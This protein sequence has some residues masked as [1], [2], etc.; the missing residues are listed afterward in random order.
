MM[1]V[2]TQTNRVLGG[3]AIDQAARRRE[4]ER[5]CPESIRRRAQAADLQQAC[6]RTPRTATPPA[7]VAPDAA[8]LL[9]TRPASC[10]TCDK[11]VG[12]GGPCPGIHSRNPGAMHGCHSSRWDAYAYIDSAGHTVIVNAAGELVEVIA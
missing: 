5:S 2:A 10:D 1:A 4:A 9:A 3:D 12:R 7:L 11:R 8:R 6:R